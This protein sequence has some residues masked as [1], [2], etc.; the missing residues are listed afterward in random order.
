MLTV[1]FGLSLSKRWLIRIVDMFPLYT[2]S[3]LGV[4]PRSCHN[5][6]M[7]SCNAT[8]KFGSKIAICDLAHGHSGQH[9]SS[10]P[11]EFEWNDD[12]HT[13]IADAVVNPN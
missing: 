12:W 8:Q 9:R 1:G 7:G 4:N 6:Q 10:L 11:N 5:Q 3:M 2:D 13:N